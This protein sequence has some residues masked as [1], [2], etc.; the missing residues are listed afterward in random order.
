M[1]PL[2]L[3]SS[4]DEDEC[5]TG[6]ALIEK[7][8]SKQQARAAEEPEPETEMQVGKGSNNKQ[9]YTSSPART[10]KRSTMNG[11]EY[12]DVRSKAAIVCDESQ[13]PDFPYRN[14]A[15]L[16]RQAENNNN[17]N[18]YY[19][20][21]S[22]DNQCTS[23][24][25]MSSQVHLQQ[26]RYVGRRT[27]PVSSRRYNGSLN[28]GGGGDED[29]DELIVYDGATTS[30]MYDE[31]DYNRRRTTTATTSQR[32]AAIY[33]HNDHNLN[34]EASSQRRAQSRRAISSFAWLQA[35]NFGPPVIQSNGQA[36]RPSRSVRTSSNS[37]N[38]NSTSNGNSN[39]DNNSFGA[40]PSLQQCGAGNSSKSTR[41]L[42]RANE[43]L[44]GGTGNAHEHRKLVVDARDEQRKWRV[45]SSSAAA[46]APM[47]YRTGCVWT[48]QTLPPALPQEPSAARYRLTQQLE[49]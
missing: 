14:S 12:E 30:E 11:S 32:N 43:L 1:S 4:N 18:Y 45:A 15:T 3:R 13:T 28:G 24:S 5:Y 20:Q 21:L 40:M 46:A 33:Q 47:A 9:F 37:N 27:I 36:S 6:S 39:N 23:S 29:E 44:I 42:S 8:A 31:D 16:Q 7:A 17:N 41:S 49:R 19:Q 25:E 34:L 26:A 2:S 38:N 48:P 10:S 22:S 35:N